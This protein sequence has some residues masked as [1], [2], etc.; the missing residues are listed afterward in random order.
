MKAIL[1]SLLMLAS[2][3]VIATKGV[4]ADDFGKTLHAILKVDDV[5][6]N[7]TTINPRFS[8]VTSGTVTFN[9]RSLTLTLNKTMPRCTLRKC[10]QV[11][12]APLNIKLALISIKKTKCSVKYTAVTPANVKSE[13]SEVVTVEDF[14][15]S[16]CP[17]LLAS[18]GIVTYQVTGTSN[19][20]KRQETAT[21]NLL[22]D[23]EFN[24][25]R[26]TLP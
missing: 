1:I 19:L 7:M 2:T 15:F 4:S 5:T 9:N 25:I 20:S 3:T 10:I 11:M 6:R 17:M 14:T 8:S 22:V 23:G 24:T 16:T 13:V 18:V 12:P 26:F 21:A